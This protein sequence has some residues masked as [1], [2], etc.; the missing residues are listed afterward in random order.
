M[1]ALLLTGALVLI[2]VLLLVLVVVLVW[3][4]RASKQRRARQRERQARW[5]VI[6]LAEDNAKLAPDQAVANLKRWHQE[7]G[8]DISVP[9]ELWEAFRN[10]EREHLRCLGA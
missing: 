6:C 9:A 8:Y 2:L 1:R 7:K 3:A 10:A 4:V 5:D